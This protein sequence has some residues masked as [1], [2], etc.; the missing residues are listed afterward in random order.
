MFC[1]PPG[2][3]ERSAPAWSQDGGQG[4]NHK[5]KIGAAEART[6]PAQIKGGRGHGAQQSAMMTDGGPSEATEYS[7]SGV[8][9]CAR[10]LRS[11][12]RTEEW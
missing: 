7:S 9:T 12:S 1:F 8:F 2:C 4:E 5:M 3:G 10:S 11:D 6:C